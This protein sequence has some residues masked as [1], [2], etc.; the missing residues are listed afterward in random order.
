MWT[1]RYTAKILILFFLVSPMVMAQEKTQVVDEIIAKVD[2]FII[3]KSDLEKAYRD[4]MNR[5]QQQISDKAAK[6]TVLEQLVIQK[7]MVAKA[8]IDSVVVEDEAVMANLERKMQYFIAQIG[9]EEEIENY[10]GKTIEEFKEELKE[11]EREQMLVAKMQQEITKD[12][13]V[14]PA[15][16]KKF[17]QAIPRDSLPYFATEVAISQIIKKPEVGQ[18]QKLRARQKLMDIR[19]QIMQ[20]LE[21]TNTYKDYEISLEANN[22]LVIEAPAGTFKGTWGLSEDFNF[23]TIQ[24]QSEVRALTRLN[25]DWIITIQDDNH[26]HLL[27]KDLENQTNFTLA[28]ANGEPINRITILSL[29][30]NWKISKAYS[31]GT[32]FAIMAKEYSEDPGSRVKGGNLGWHKR[33]ELVPPYEATAFTLKPGQISMPVESEFGYHLIQLIE[34]RGNQYNSRHILIKTTSS[35]GDIEAAK[36]YLDSLRTSIINDSISFEKAAKEY[37]DDK[38]TAGSGGYLLDEMGAASIPV[39]QLDPTMY[40]TIDTMQVGEISRPIKFTMPDGS[41]AVKIVYYKSKIP[42]HQASLIEDYNKIQNAALREKKVRV[43]N[44][45]FEEA[46]SEVFVFI[47]DKYRNCNIL[48]E[49]GT[50]M[51]R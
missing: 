30:R 15:E 9:S 23:M 42:P 6:C 36:D 19:R 11:E 18:P 48:A 44:E 41:E 22:N 35:E 21:L 26:I 43:T 12:V 10:Y 51:R 13:N 39:D 31:S 32:S 46:Q 29:T 4:F 45:W 8:E 38:Q 28:A 24:I 33:G 27:N 17:F 3:L 7:L 2:N 37:S 5:N 14:T 34:R 20:G 49:T 40:F 50:A 1:N 25:G 16:V 47:D